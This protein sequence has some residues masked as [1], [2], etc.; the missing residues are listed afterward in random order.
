M[1]WSVIPDSLLIRPAFRCREVRLISHQLVAGAP[2]QVLP[3]R[4]I[5]G[6][7]PYSS[8]AETGLRDAVESAAI[9]FPQRQRPLDSLMQDVLVV[10]EFSEWLLPG[11]FQNPPSATGTGL[12]SSR[13]P[14]QSL[15]NGAKIPVLGLGTWPLRGEESAAQVRTGIEA[16]YRLIDTAENYRNE[17]SVGQGI[18]DSGIERSE[19]FVTTKFDLKW[20]S[21]DGVRRAYEASRKRLGSDYIDLLMIHWPNPS[22]GRYVDAIQGLQAI[23]EDGGIRAIGTSNFKPRHL[24]R[25]LNETGIVPDINQIQLCPYTTRDASRAYHAAHGIVTESWA[26]IGGSKT[27]ELRHDPLIRAIADTHG[28][29]ATQVVLRWHIQLGLVAIPRSSNPARIGENIDIFDFELNERELNTISALD[30]GEASILDS[31]VF[32]H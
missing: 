9:F 7:I 11:Q 8:P 24:R 29:S 18:R 28:K 1:A 20:H 12:I 17:D 25:V 19:V 26:P 23:L 15:R 13:V 4:G 27:P 2:G 10:I 16:G 14:T 6:L 5:E 22:D 31:D 30:R 32:G 21:V 3:T